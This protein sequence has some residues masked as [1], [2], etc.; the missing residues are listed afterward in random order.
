MKV[1]RVGD[2]IFRSHP[3]PLLSFLAPSISP[4]SWTNRSR[5]TSYSPQIVCISTNRRPY[6]SRSSA[7]QAPSTAAAEK[8]EEPA[9]QPKG[10]YKSE[11]TS[12]PAYN[13]I[14]DSMNFTK[15][16]TANPRIGGNRLRYFKGPLENSVDLVTNAYKE[17]L[18]SRIPLI[19]RQG[20]IAKSV[21]MGPSSNKLAQDV[22]EDSLTR[23][24]RSISRSAAPAVRLD[25]YIG[26]GENV[27]KAMDLG[28]ALRRLDITLAL[29]NVRGE[30]FQQRFHERPGLKR[31][32]LKSS[33]WR[34]RFKEGF[35]AVVAKVQD[36]RKQGW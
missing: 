30:V 7:F 36:M 9:E 21:G 13:K 35:Q 18:R 4:S 26:R 20:E 14:M 8:V 32:R 6:A 27:T 5:L 33:R 3:S 31:K 28:R 2:V 1:R 24:E 15:R 19:N 16:S 11:E 29:N 10:L 12:E 25:A 23:A 34:K 22:A 17:D